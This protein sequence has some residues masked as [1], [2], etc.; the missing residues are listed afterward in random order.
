MLELMSTTSAVKIIVIFEC[1]KKVVIALL[2]LR[3]VIAHIQILV[4]EPNLNAKMIHK[5][6]MFLDG[7][8]IESCMPIQD[9]QM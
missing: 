6:L 5:S 4:M 1:V 3:V 9:K 8:E 2:Q 7:T